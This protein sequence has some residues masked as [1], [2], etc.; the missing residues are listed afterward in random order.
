MTPLNFFLIWPKCNTV[1]TQTSVYRCFFFPV[2]P[3][4]SKDLG[5]KYIFFGTLLLSLCLERVFAFFLEY[6]TE[7]LLQNY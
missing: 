1:S 4:F 5:Y 3:V 6:C 2:C 7:N